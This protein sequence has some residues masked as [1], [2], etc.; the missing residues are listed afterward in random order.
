MDDSHTRTNKRGEHDDAA[1]GTSRAAASVSA[2]DV[3][4]EDVNA[5]SVRTEDVSA[6]DVSTE[7]LAHRVI[8]ALLRSVVRTA[9]AFEIPLKDVVQLLESAYFRDVRGRATT[10]RSAARHLGVSQRTADRLAAQNRETFLLPELRHHLPRRI[11]FMLAAEPLSEARIAQLLPDVTEQD[12]AAALRGLL[13]EGRITQDGERTVTYRPVEGVRS[14]PRDTWVQRVGALTS[15]SDNLADAAFGRFFA[16]DTHAFARTLS[17]PLRPE[18]ID[19]LAD[20]YRTEMLPRIVAMSDEA[21]DTPDSVPMQLSICW[22]PYET[23][24][25]H[26]AGAPSVAEPDHRGE[27]S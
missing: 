8:F 15:F 18:D 13:D 26:R 27:E 19:A 24:A 3:S 2:E 9:G 7:E 4:T 20:W 16:E 10:L 23:I 25:Q 1:E 11:E 22:A 21:S 12:V 17:F 5:A 6:E 14:L